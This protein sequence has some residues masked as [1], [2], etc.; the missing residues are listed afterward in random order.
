M[1]ELLLY[2]NNCPKCQVIKSKLEA[3]DIKFTESDRVDEL[4]A[5]GIQ[6]LPALKVGEKFLN[7][8]DANNWINSQSSQNN[9]EKEE[10]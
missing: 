6:S 3:Q 8:V 10:E 4:I 2:T 1:E 9:F 7:F 5:H